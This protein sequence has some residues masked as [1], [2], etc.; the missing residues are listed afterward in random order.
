ML[1]LCSDCLSPALAL[2]RGPGVDA[3]RGPGLGLCDSVCTLS[4]TPRLEAHSELCGARVEEDASSP[5]DSSHFP[6]R[7]FLTKFSQRV[8]QPLLFS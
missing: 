1:V 5:S 8:A 3:P 6:G 7:Q 4:C 2:V